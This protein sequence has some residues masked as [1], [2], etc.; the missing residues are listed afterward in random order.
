[1]LLNIQPSTREVIN[2]SVVLKFSAYKREQ[3]KRLLNFKLQ[4]DGKSSV[5]SNVNI[6]SLNI[7]T[8]V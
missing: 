2:Q 1:M 4:I 8:F 7:G 5:M 3:F 6:R